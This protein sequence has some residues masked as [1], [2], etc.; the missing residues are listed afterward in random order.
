MKRL[1]LVLVLVLACL[2]GCVAPPGKSPR[3]QAQQVTT[4]SCTRCGGSQEQAGNCPKCGM[5][6]QAVSSSQPPDTGGKK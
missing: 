2:A 4:Y 5:A 3:S 6:L 1:P